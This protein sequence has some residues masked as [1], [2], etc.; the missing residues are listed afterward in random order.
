MSRF[1]YAAPGELF[2][3]RSVSRKSRV[4]YRRFDTAAE[5]VRFAVEELSDD[6]LRATTVE[7]DEVRVKGDEIR[8]LYQNAN[9]PLTRKVVAA[10]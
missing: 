6:V 10:A 9:Y 2:C 8:E 3:T 7:A 4:T 5:A 1:D